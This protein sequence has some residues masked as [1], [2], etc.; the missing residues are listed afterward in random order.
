AGHAWMGSSHRDRPAGDARGRTSI[1]N[2]RRGERHPSES[3]SES[4][5]PDELRRATVSSR[6]R[7]ESGWPTTHTA[8]N[9]AILGLDLDALA[10]AETYKGMDPYLVRRLHH[11]MRGHTYA[12][13][14]LGAVLKVNPRPESW[15]ESLVRRLT[16]ADLSRR[17]E[18]TIESAIRVVIGE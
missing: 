6:D 12:L 11:A 2:R 3:A 18:I 7:Q 5:G 13:G 8:A 4:R 1:R 16:T 15:V 9:G 10:K 14:V 17:A